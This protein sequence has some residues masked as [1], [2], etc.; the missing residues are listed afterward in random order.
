MQPAGFGAQ[1]PVPPAWQVPEP[2][3]VIAP[4]AFDPLP[5]LSFVV[6]GAAVSPTTSAP[7][8]Q[9][10]VAPAPVERDMLATG[11]L[12]GMP[13]VDPPVTPVPAAVRPAQP[14]PSKRPVAP[15]RPIPNFDKLPPNIAASLQRLAGGSIPPVSEKPDSDAAE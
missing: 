7:P 12:Q 3:P 8:L 6:E 9:P 14:P 1:P 2:A 13:A 4:A 11:P 5:P 15:V 10:P